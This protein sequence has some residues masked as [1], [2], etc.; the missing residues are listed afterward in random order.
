MGTRRGIDMWKAIS[1]S[2]ATFQTPDITYDGAASILGLPDLKLLMIQRQ[3]LLGRS[4]MFVCPAAKL[5]C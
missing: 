4:A 2:T 5:D 3:L 1:A